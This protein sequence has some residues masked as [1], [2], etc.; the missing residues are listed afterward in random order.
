M[1]GNC[2]P[3]F[4]GMKFAPLLL[5]FWAASC[6]KPQ[7]RHA[8]ES[9]VSQAQTALKERGRELEAA[10]VKLAEAEA[11]LDYVLRQDREGSDDL[12][13][14]WRRKQRER[15]QSELAHAKKLVNSALHAYRENGRHYLKTE[16]YHRQVNGRYADPKLVASWSQQFESDPEL[17]ESV[18]SDPPSVTPLLTAFA[19]I[20]LI[21]ISLLFL[22]ILLRR[23]SRGA[24]GFRVRRPEEPPL[25]IEKELTLI[26]SRYRLKNII[27][28]GG[29][30]KVWEGRDEGAGN[31]LIAVK[32]MT[33]RPGG[34][35]ERI[36]KLYLQEA[37]T[38]AKLRHPNIVRLFEIVEIGIHLYLIFEHIEGKTLAH[39]LAERT[40]MSLDAM[41]SI[42]IP[43]TDA[44]VYAHGEG[45]IHR[46]LKPANIMVDTA[47]KVWVMDFGIARAIGSP[48]P[49]EPEGEEKPKKNPR[50][51]LVARTS[52][53]WGT[54]AYRCPE[55]SR[56]TV[57]P[58][59]D[60]FSLGVTLY[61]CLTGRLP[62]GPDGFSQ[63]SFDAYAPPSA[64]VPELPASVDA[65]LERMLERA[66][67]K[68]IPS[69]SELAEMLREL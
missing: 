39:L 28:R 34:R 42:L 5:L 22:F 44:L 56:G 46:D 15:K 40:K 7:V 8:A 21:V 35:Y 27:G 3:S 53:V 20:G 36:R 19:M 62:F 30:G 49:E 58:A 6:D 57:S 26:R 23:S 1:A 51:L 54:P 63:E 37:K 4:S 52:L 16:L 68:R 29:M 64:S 25:K 50:N 24:G 69:A 43:V 59:S 65:L 41:R 66:R 31:R 48:E 11:G 10:R 2:S 12:G 9:A 32:Q 38:V 55:S 17:T 61:E 33:A 47:G 45:I 67:S 13:A 18:L 14:Q 60:I